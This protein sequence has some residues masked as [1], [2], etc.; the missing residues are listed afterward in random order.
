MNRKSLTFFLFLVAVVRCLPLAASS[1]DEPPF[2]EKYLLAGKLEEGEQALLAHLAKNEQDDQARFGLGVLQ[3]C[4]AIDHLGQSL[5]RYGAGTEDFFLNDMVPFL[6]MP[7]P[8]NKDAEEVKSRDVRAILQTIIDDL[9]A[10]DETLER[11]GSEDVKLPLH[12]LAIRFDFDQDGSSGESESLKNI[13]LQYM[14]RRDRGVTDETIVVLDQAD[15]YWL[16]GYCHLLQAMA[17]SMLAYDFQPLWDVAAHLAFPNVKNEMAYLKSKERRR[18]FDEGTI[19]D[20]IAAIHSIQFKLADAQRLKR[21]HSHLLEVTRLS[22]KSWDAIMAETDDDQEWIPN[23]RQ[24]SAVTRAAIT[25]EMVK[26]WRDF[27]DELDALL[28]GEKLA[29][30]WRG[31]DAEIGINL[32]KIFA[33]PTDFDLVYWIQGSGM[34][35][36]LEKGELTSPETWSR[37]QRVFRGN[38]IGFAIWFN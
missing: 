32:W 22:R 25:D 7:V 13:Y 19:L 21:A 12:L 1:A 35:P 17:E 15:V 4:Q 5:Y 14:G 23:P 18:R 10:A 26:T 34:K 37:F 8:E 33:E 16:R 27:L 31:S 2:V 3:F 9:S 24:K 38:F 28:K 6:R 36:F 29:P 30:F 11:I 20:T